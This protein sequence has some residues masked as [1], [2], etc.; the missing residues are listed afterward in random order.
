MGLID[1]VKRILVGAALTSALVTGAY[2][3]E[4]PIAKDNEY[5]HSK[6]HAYFAEKPNHTAYRTNE[7][8][9][10]RI[11]ERSV[12]KFEEL[13]TQLDTPEKVNEFCQ[14]NQKYGSDILDGHN[15]TDF[16]ESP[17]E[18]Y[19]SGKGDCEDYANFADY[20]LKKHG[21]E[22]CMITLSTLEFTSDKDAYCHAICLINNKEE[23]TYG[24]IDNTGHF[25]GFK[26]VDSLFRYAIGQYYGKSSPWLTA[27]NIHPDYSKSSG[28]GEGW[29]F[30]NPCWWD[31]VSEE[32]V[33]T[34]PKK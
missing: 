30:L 14:K 33:K 3:A 10:F 21:Y 18:F 32:V 28:A 11:P 26:D 6:I 27:Q 4:P 29:K 25:V 24:Y 31:E 17:L 8:F 23:K 15:G 19:L 9:F 16:M 13:I 12:S 1:T 5:M 22:S 34:L 7:F 2:A 20:A